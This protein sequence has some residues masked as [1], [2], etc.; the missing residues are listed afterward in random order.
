MRTARSLP[1]GGVSV[2]GESVWG[3]LSIVVSV[4]ETPMNRMTDKCKKITLLHVKMF[5][6]EMMAR[7]LCHW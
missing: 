1:Y 2:R 4:R 5:N 6:I 7:T 3:S